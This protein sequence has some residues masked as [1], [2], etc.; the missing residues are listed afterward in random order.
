MS[1]HAPWH[2]ACILPD[3][4]T[5]SQSSEV[6]FSAITLLMVLLYGIMLFAP[7]L[8]LVSESPSH[9]QILQGQAAIPKCI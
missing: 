4:P 5:K 1:T 3:P 2:L 6:L 8:R 9:L 7:R